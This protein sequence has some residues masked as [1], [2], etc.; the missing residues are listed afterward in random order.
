MFKLDL[1]IKAEVGDTIMVEYPAKGIVQT[2]LALYGLPSLGLFLGY[3]LAYNLTGAEA[4]SALAAL[5]GLVVCWLAARPVARLIDGKIGQPRIVA[6]VSGSSWLS[7]IQPPQVGNLGG[8]PDKNN[9]RVLRATIASTTTTARGRL[10]V[11]A[12]GD[13]KS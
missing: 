3:F 8:C 11:M 2:M 7:F 9:R 12:A 13:G 5:G 4:F 1:N 10:R 6:T